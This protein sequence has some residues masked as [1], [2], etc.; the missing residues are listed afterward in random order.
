MSGHAGIDCAGYA[1]AGAVAQARA[2][3]GAFDF[4]G[5]YLPDYGP[6]TDELAFLKAEG[7]AVLCLWNG[8]NATTCG[9]G[10]A[11]GYQQGQLAATGWGNLGAPKG[12]A[13]YVDIEQPWSP[14]GEFLHGWLDGCHAS[15]YVGGAYI[16]PQ[17]GANHAASWAYARRQ[18]SAPG[19]VYTSQN[20]VYANQ[21][22][23]VHD[24]ALGPNAAAAVPGYE[25]D[26]V[27]WQ[28]WENNLN[29]LVDL[30]CASDRGYSLMWGGTAPAPPKPTYPQDAHV[31]APGMLKSAPSHGSS[32]AKD[33]HHKDVFLERGAQVVILAAPEQTDDLWQRVQL[34]NPEQVVHGFFLA[35]SLAGDT[36]R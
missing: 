29:G 9:Y 19:V 28:T 18:S 2:A 32:A 31:T 20:E 27:I 23:L 10:Y 13:I 5:R 33:P 25:D 12:V 8:V 4:C 16:N 15:G 14:S 17:Y 36:A 1:N 30:D 3:Y 6:S 11:Y 7:L 21:N 26:S 22:R 24:F 34:I 35:R